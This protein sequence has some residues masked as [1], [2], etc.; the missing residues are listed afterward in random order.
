MWFSVITN[1]CATLHKILLL[2][3]HFPYIHTDT[4]GTCLTTLRSKKHVN[5]KV[6]YYTRVCCHSHTLSQQSFICSSTKSHVCSQAT[7]IHSNIIRHVYLLSIEVLFSNF[8]HT[9]V[10]NIRSQWS[11]TG[12]I[13]FHGK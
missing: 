1:Y 7:Y 12:D 6:V 5:V 11:E 13:S 2:Y 8:V 10:G 3:T 9:Y 4:A